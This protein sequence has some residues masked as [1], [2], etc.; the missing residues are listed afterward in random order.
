MRYARGAFL[1]AIKTSITEIDECDVVVPDNK[2]NDFIKFTHEVSKKFDVRIPSFAHTGDGNLHV[3]ICRD[4]LSQS[5][6]EIML[7]SSAAK[8]TMF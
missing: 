8:D 2:V 7:K 5:E 1:E 4:D 3:Y 6:W